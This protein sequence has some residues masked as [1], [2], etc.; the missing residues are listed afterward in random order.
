MPWM[1]GGS[2]SGY[3]GH[4]AVREQAVPSVATSQDLGLQRGPQ[5][6][7]VG[8]LTS[9]VFQGLSRLRGSRIL[10]PK[11]VGFEARLIPL[12]LAPSGVEL[13]EQSEPHHA[14][15]RLSRSVGLPSALPDP[16]GI[17]LRIPDAYG[18][19]LHQDLLLVSSGSAPVARHALLPRRRFEGGFYSSLLPYRFADEIVLVGASA[20]AGAAGAGEGGSRTAD[21][22]G[23]WFHLKLASPKGMWRSV[24]RLELG[25]RLPADE[26]EELCFNPWHTGGNIEPLGFLNALR[27]PAYRGSQAGRLAARDTAQR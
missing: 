22:G 11:G 17:A 7:V 27:L 24:A 3:A 21:Q 14:V 12:P 19:G 20:H 23:L 13:F 15:V 1:R 26:T 10:H 16:C 9:G 4:V 5:L 2:M 8:A 6:P 25:G 18:G